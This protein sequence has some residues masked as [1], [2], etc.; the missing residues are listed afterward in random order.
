MM[1]ENARESDNHRGG[2]QKGRRGILR[3]TKMVWAPVEEQQLSSSAEEVQRCT[4]SILVSLPEQGMV[5][6]T[7]KEY[8]RSL[9]QFSE[10]PTLSR[11]TSFNSYHS[12]ASIPQ[13]IPEWLELC[14]EDPVEI[15]LDLGFGADEP[16]ICT[17]IPARFL[18]CASAA[19]GINT[20][21]FLEAQKQRMDIENPNLYG[22]FQQLKMLNHVANAFSSLLSEVNVL[23]NKTEEKNGEESVQISLGREP[24]EQ[25]RRMGKLFKRASK[26]EGRRNCS[27]EGWRSLKMRNKS[28]ITSEKPGA[29]GEE[30]PASKNNHVQNHL[31]QLAEQAPLQACDDLTSDHPPWALLSKQWPHSSRAAKQTPPCCVYNGSVK[32]RTQKENSI[33]MDKL[34]NLFCCDGNGPDSFE[35]EEV[36][37]FEEETG[38][39]LDV[40]PGTLGTVVNRANSCQSDSSGFL[41]ELPEPLPLQMPSLPSSQQHAEGGCPAREHQSPSLRSSQD[42][43]PE[44]DESDS[45]S[46]V[47]TSFSSQD[48]SAL[49][50][51][52][53]TSVVE[54]GSQLEAMEDSEEL[55]TPDKAVHKTTAGECPNTDGRLQQHPL[56]SQT[57]AE[58]IAGT[59][60]A[61][62]TC[63]LELMASHI[64]EVKDGLMRPVGAGDVCEHSHHRGSPGSLGNDHAEEKCPH[65]DTE[66]PRAVASSQP[67]PDV[68]NT[69]TTQERPPQQVSKGSEVMPCT[70]NLM[71]VSEKSIPHLRS[72]QDLDKLVEVISQEKPRSSAV[73]PVPPRSASGVG[74]PP[75]SAD[76]STG[77]SKSVTTQMSSNLASAAQSAMA[78]GTDSRGS[79]SECTECDPVT[80]TGPG[81]G[82]EIKQ[83]NDASVQTYQCEHRPWHCC[84]APSN[85]ALAHTAQPLT[86]CS[87][88][89]TGFPTLPAG[90]LCHSGPALCCH[91]PACC[92]SA[93]QQPSP[94]PS[95]CKH[96]H[97]LHAQ[98]TKVLEILQETVVSELCSCTV[99]EMEAMKTVCQSLREH[100]LEIEEH[101]TGQQAL[102]S[103]DM[104]EEERIEAQQLQTL[105]EA[106]RQQ[107]EELEFQLGDRARQ[108]RESILLQFELLTGKTPEHY[109]NPPQLN[110]TGNKNGPSAF[111]PD[112]S[113]QAPCSDVTCMTH[114]PPSVLGNSRRMF[115]SAQAESD[116]TLLSNCPIGGKEMNVFL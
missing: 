75:P 80:A 91:R 110:W 48:W 81:L 73:V 93:R 109:P 20:R 36:Q 55:L 52:G 76:T 60:T 24:K 114:F 9:H 4:D 2:Q 111:P 27:S 6:M 89:D 11:G 15:L 22:R 57:E 63:P 82:R 69:L 79:T 29:C 31:S 42:C 98:V 103:R 38:N 16:D 90:S 83:F 67:C 10:I 84:L 37:S 23:Q 54:K 96:H 107:M 39:P 45:K 66:V 13:S 86:K 85:K 32:E 30:L 14:E 58:V 64:A 68:D 46:M 95:A 108:I 7:V 70:G 25:R 28:F 115:P 105:R 49:E 106:L 56:R 33:Q 35:M 26:Q 101:L 3:S 65:V 71:Q 40:T 5:Q 59:V 41:E 88:L 12:A 74:S 102:F 61:K 104:T 51:K 62:S 113:Q 94:V 112:D 50:E 99:P 17:Q 47:S 34:K 78:L 77:S 100:L 18:G 19:R 1:A 44:S 92:P 53:S 43:Q 72:S 97:H 21:V 87:L 116:P 8:M